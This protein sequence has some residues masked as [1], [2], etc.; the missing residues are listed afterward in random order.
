[1]VAHTVISQKVF[2]PFS[3]QT[4]AC[5]ASVWHLPSDH[6]KEQLLKSLGI[7]QL[8]ILRGEKKLEIEM[9]YPSLAC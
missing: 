4:E 8:N 7:T 5:L 9:E 2:H 6:S 3:D 1:M